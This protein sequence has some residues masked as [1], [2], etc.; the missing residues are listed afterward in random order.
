GHYTPC[1]GCHLYLHAVRI[2]L[3]R[4]LGNVPIIGGE[5]E[6]HSGKVKV[7]QCAPARAVLSGLRLG[8]KPRPY[9]PAA[10]PG[11]QVIPPE[12]TE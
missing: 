9:M 10:Y 2:P 7:N 6:S 1:T 11:F 8:N 12:K 3:A 4:M 5:R